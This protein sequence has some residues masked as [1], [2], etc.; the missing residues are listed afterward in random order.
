[1]PSPRF[2]K[3]KKEKKER[4]LE[5]AGKE[6]AEHGYDG[7]TINL[8]LEHAGLSTGAAY[9]YFHNKADLFAEVARYHSDKLFGMIPE[10][11]E[12]HVTNSQ[13]FWYLL[14]ALFE[15]VFG[16]AFEIHRVFGGLRGTWKNSKEAKQIEGLEVVFG[17][18]EALLSKLIL[19]GRRV[20]AVR[21][22]FPEDLM[23]HLMIA[24]DEG[25]DNWL[26]AQPDDLDRSDLR[27]T[28]ELLLTTLGQLLKPPGE[29]SR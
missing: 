7:A 17:R 8:I 27:P 25:F 29:E 18:Q 10:D 19:V 4:I 13:S 23:V 15:S 6:F 11:F 16:P 20:G 14:T 12:T 28:M 9:Y 26:Q 1:M 24:L 21:R 22:D 2:Q 5:G 3:L